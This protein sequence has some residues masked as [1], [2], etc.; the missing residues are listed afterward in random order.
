MHRTL[1]VIY[2]TI[3]CITGYAQ[4]SFRFKADITTKIKNLDGSFQYTK[5]T[6]LYDR[7]V[8]K[9]IYKISFPQKEIFVSVDTLI[10]KFVD[11]K[12][13][14]V[15]G[16]P[17]KPEYSIYHFILNNDIADFGLKKSS[18]TIANVEKVD[19]LILTKWIPPSGSKSFFGNIMVSTKNKRLNSVLIYNSKGELVNR[20]IY[21]KYQSVNGVEIPTEILTVT[22]IGEVKKYQIVEFHNV[23]INE[24]GNDSEYNF[25]LSKN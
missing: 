9:I 24:M 11:N 21:K 10:Y 20:Q 15:V 4:N 18:F 2:F 13:A 7:N 22:Y 5:G 25:N 19:D 6:A 16:N 8:K 23:A 14:S 12:L 3:I 1:F 17:L